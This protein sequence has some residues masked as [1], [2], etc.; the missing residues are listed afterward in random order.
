VLAG[1]SFGTTDQTIVPGTITPTCD[2]ADA[3]LRRDIIHARQRHI[4]IRAS[5][6]PKYGIRPAKYNPRFATTDEDLICED[7]HSLSLSLSLVRAPLNFD[8]K[9]P[10]TTPETIAEDA[11]QCCATQN[12]PD[13]ET[14]FD[15]RPCRSCLHN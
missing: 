2:F 3:R 8:T 11:E 7:W 10:G 14:Y 9:S 15:D 1:G 4:Y 13:A 12:F 6:E 5:K